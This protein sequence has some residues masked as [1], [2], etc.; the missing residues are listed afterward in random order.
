MKSESVPYAKEMLR[1]LRGIKHN[2]E[3]LNKAAHDL[4]QSEAEAEL[5]NS[6]KTLKESF[7]PASAML[8]RL[9]ILLEYWLENRK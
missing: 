7:E 9:E 8:G 1:S 5:I 2:I 4:G 3:K 6:T